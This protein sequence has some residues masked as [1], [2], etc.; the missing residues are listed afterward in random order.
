LIRRRRRSSRPREQPL[1]SKN[2]KFH[3]SLEKAAPAE[4]Y[5]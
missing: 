4:R 3:A 2:N 5:N 1:P